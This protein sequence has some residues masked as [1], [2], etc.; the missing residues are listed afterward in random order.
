MFLF[1]SV[2]FYFWTTFSC[3]CVC[4]LAP[5]PYFAGC[6]HPKKNKT[7]PATTTLTNPK[8]SEFPHIPHRLQ[9]YRRRATIFFSFIFVFVW[10]LVT[11]AVR[12]KCQ[13]SLQESAA[14]WFMERLNATIWSLFFF[15]LVCPATRCSTDWFISSGGKLESSCRSAKAELDQQK[16]KIK[17]CE[18]QIFLVAKS[19]T[20]GN[21]SMQVI[22]RNVVKKLQQQLLCD[23]KN[24]NDKTRIRSVKFF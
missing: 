4:L 18:P 7:V 14:G 15:F 2:A 9:L 20:W 3:F 24:D 10:L 21:K 16:G 19:L 5:W 11:Q 6:Q 1:P 23:S 8:V 13:N 22:L 12:T 17:Q